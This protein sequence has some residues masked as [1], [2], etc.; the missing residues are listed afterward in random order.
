MGYAVDFQS[1][2]VGLIL[3]IVN[4]FTSFLKKFS[5]F[6][7]VTL[8]ALQ[9]LFWEA[10]A[11]SVDTAFLYRHIPNIYIDTYPIFKQEAAKKAGQ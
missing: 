6:F 7:H 10:G 2:S 9:A 3:W 11:G 4:F 5:K 1:D 8:P